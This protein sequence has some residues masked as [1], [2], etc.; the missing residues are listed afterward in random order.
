MKNTIIVIFVLLFAIVGSGC[1]SAGPEFDSLE[2]YKN[3]KWT[4][5]WWYDG[6]SS[7]EVKLY[8]DGMTDSRAKELAL[9]FFEEKYFLKQTTTTTLSKDSVVFG[10]V[11]ISNELNRTVLIGVDLIGS[12]PSSEI[13]HRSWYV[14]AKST[15]F[16]VLP[17]G[18]YIKW[19]NWNRKREESLT[20]MNIGIE[21]T[22]HLDRNVNGVVLVTQP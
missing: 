5:G 8:L 1:G 19:F 10:T 15:V 22:W 7:E 13:G 18:K 6:M 9:K 2:D 14:A 21:T 17:P 20:I 12:D 4:P 11:A 3:G 16:D